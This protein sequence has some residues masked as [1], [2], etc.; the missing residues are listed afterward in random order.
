MTIAK[1][2]ASKLSVA[3]VAIAMI[4]LAIAPA[5]NAAETSEDLQ[6]TINDLLA[7]VAALQ[8]QV[9]GGTTTTTTT[10]GKACGLFSMDLKMGA[11]SADVKALQMFLNS[12]AD[13][14]V[15]MTGAGSKGMETMY[16][17]PAT[18]AAV[19][20]FQVKYRAEILSPAGL[21]NPTGFFGPGSRAQANKLCAG[22]MDDDSDDSSD[23]SADDSSDD[24]A[25][26]SGEASLDR[27]E[28]D[29]ADD[30]DVSEGAEDVEIGM[31]TVEFTDGDAE[32]SRLDVALT[33]NG[34]SDS[35]AWDTF[36]TVSLWVD[37]EKIG[38]MDASSKDDYLGDEDNGIIR[39]SDLK[40]VAMED[41]QVEITIAATL[42]DNLDSENLGVW[43][44]KA[45][46]LRFFDADGV[47]TTQEGT[48]VIDDTASF[49]IEV[50]GIDEELKFSLGDNNPDST[51]IVVDETSTTNG[52]T[53]LEYTLKAKD[54]DITL[55][56]L[57]VALV[58]S[59]DIDDV[60][61]DI[62]I[63]IDGQTFSD[64]TKLFT[65][66]T[67]TVTQTYTFDI[68]G[69]VTIDD[70]DE[71]T[72]KVILDLKRQNGNYANGTTIQAKVGTTQRDATDAEGEDDLTSA[73]SQFTGSAIGD[74]HTLVATGILVPVD[75]FSST[76]DTL[77][78]ND[79]IG[80]Y[81]IEFEVTAVEED[82]YIKDFASTTASAATGGIEFSIDPAAAG[83]VTAVLDST[84]DEDTP[85]VFTVRDGETETFTLT[86]T[87]DPA[88]AGS[89]RVLL[90][91]VWSSQNVD[92]V[93][94]S[95]IFVPSPVTD[96]R[97]ASK[98]INQ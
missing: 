87:Y 59:D 84:S 6:K 48:P 24:S 90:E 15:S 86:V 66:T 13:T 74:V 14:M 26:L 49:N 64:D 58:T 47:A 1:D 71:V 20:K 41:E 53:T 5:V 50:A 11:T 77:G 27:F 72:V 79:T 19:S 37:G 43:D 16:F 42:Q 98:A 4:F 69:D 45:K 56:D 17:G 8:S 61:S 91:E 95:V 9:G 12:D 23:D 94:G 21:V 7:Q 70:G 92:G 63:D 40:L 83:T 54:G 18:G 81:T 62:E 67:A 73:N 25:D 65:G 68:D 34:G 36:D 44:V 76:I 78:Q 31:A 80:E 97:T 29:D 85:G 33:D 51:N 82:F 75:G 60:V 57:S 89:F 55:N 22:S 30:T 38:E 93:T 2:F 52:V 32:I 96:F 39:F 28:L 46:S 35:D 3:F 88:V 10:P